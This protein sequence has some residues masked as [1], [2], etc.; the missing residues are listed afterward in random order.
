MSDY[1][2]LEAG[3]EVLDLLGLRSFKAAHIANV[4]R[5]APS[6]GD[7]ARRDMFYHPAAFVIDKSELIC[8]QLCALLQGDECCAESVRSETAC[9]L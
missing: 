2:R 4:S 5:A 7:S 6:E 3:S 8:L 1:V 9:R